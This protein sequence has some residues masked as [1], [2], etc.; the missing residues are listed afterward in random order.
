MGNV[1][2]DLSSIFKAVGGKLR[3]RFMISL[4]D[5][6]QRPSKVSQTLD[7]PLSNL[8][9]IFNEL[10]EVKLVES[11]EKEGIVY[12]R[13]THL[14]ERW[15]SA[16]IDILSEKISE[17][18]IRQEDFFHSWRRYLSVGLSLFVLLLAL[19]RGIMLSQPTFIVGGIILSL[20]VFLI[21]EKVK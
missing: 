19:V 2:E 3:A 12:W 11:F 21:L 13:L 1:E 5:G 6:P 18:S 4:R 7:A 20:L 17:A 10:K 8:Y 9:R 15:L 16:N 14:G